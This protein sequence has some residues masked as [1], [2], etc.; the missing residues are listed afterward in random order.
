MRDSC[1]QRWFQRLCSLVP[2]PPPASG[3]SVPCC[4]R[5]VSSL[6]LCVCVFSSRDTVM[7][8][9]GPSI[10]RHRSLSSRICREL[11]DSGKDMGVAAVLGGCLAG[12]WGRCCQGNRRPPPS[13]LQQLCSTSARAFW[14][15][16]P[17]WTKPQTRRSG[18]T[19]LPPTC[20]V[21]T[22]SSST[23]GCRAAK[24]RWHSSVCQEPGCFPHQRGTGPGLLSTQASVPSVSCP[25]ARDGGCIGEWGCPV[26]G[27]CRIQEYGL[28][29]ALLPLSAGRGSSPGVGGR[30][31][32]RPPSVATVQ[33]PAVCGHADLSASGPLSDPQSCGSGALLTSRLGSW[34]AGLLPLLHL[35][36][37]FG[38]EW[39]DSLALSSGSLWW[40]PWAP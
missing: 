18:R 33:T 8:D 30:S 17:T 13:P 10:P 36:Q 37:W 23:T 39:H 32:S 2:R 12:G 40:R 7:Y 38:P 19:P 6:C 35:G 34:W 26:Q 20:S 25:L 16:W 27:P 1:R 24:P 3:L 15:T 29:P 4:H 22:T 11:L 21:P 31:P 14:S 28:F 5:A 9:L